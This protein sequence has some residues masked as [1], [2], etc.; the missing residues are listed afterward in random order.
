[1]EKVFCADCGAK[2]KIR[3]LEPL[4]LKSFYRIGYCPKCETIEKPHISLSSAVGKALRGIDKKTGEFRLRKE[5]SDKMK[6][7]LIVK[8]FPRIVV[9]KPSEWRVPA[10]GRVY[11]TKERTAKV[12]PEMA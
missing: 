7:D 6:R 4:G 12:F 11:K 1:M 8:T 5:E 10:R 2:L 9:T 3:D